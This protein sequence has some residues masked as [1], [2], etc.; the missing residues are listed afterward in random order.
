MART[1]RPPQA[2]KSRL[3]MVS[4]RLSDDELAAL[5]RARGGQNRS[6]YVRSVVNAATKREKK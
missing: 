1:G 3:T 5:E 4:F 6:D 2:D